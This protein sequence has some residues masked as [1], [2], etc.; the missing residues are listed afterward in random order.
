MPQYWCPDRGEQRS[1]GPQASAL[2]TTRG[3]KVRCAAADALCTSIATFTKSAHNCTYAGCIPETAPASAAWLQCTCQQAAFPDDLR[4]A[5][6]RGLREQYAAKQRQQRTDADQAR[7]SRRCG[8]PRKQ[9]MRPWLHQNQ[10]HN[11]AAAA[12]KPHSTRHRSGLHRMPCHCSPRKR[13]AAAA[14]E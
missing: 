12:T 3:N 1:K 10:N 9:G 2:P 6:G 8:P 4:S 13:P 11:L 14:E 7:T 5:R